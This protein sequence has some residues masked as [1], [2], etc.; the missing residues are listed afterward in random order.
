[1]TIILYTEEMLEQDT[2]FKNGSE[3]IA[4]MEKLH[5][6]IVAQATNN[7]FEGYAD[8][9]NY[10]PSDGVETEIFIS[11]SDWK[12]ERLHGYGL[13]VSTHSTC[14]SLIRALTIDGKN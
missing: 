8:V 12:E 10:G 11:E 13:Q 1:M 3:D 5:K 6:S 2:L 9:I 7:G 4:T 14:Y